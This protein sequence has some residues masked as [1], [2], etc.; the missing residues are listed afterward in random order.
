MSTIG[1]RTIVSGY[2]R[3]K[4]R[5][6]GAEVETTMPTA[7][8]DCTGCQQMR[9]K[10]I[11]MVPVKRGKFGIKKAPALFAGGR[12]YDSPL[13]RRFAEELQNRAR[14]IDPDIRSIVEKAPVDLLA[15]ITWRIDFACEERRRDGSWRLVRY[16]TKGPEDREYA[17]KLRLYRLVGDAPLFIV[18][19]RGRRREVQV[20]IPAP[21]ATVQREMEAVLARRKES[22]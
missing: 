17:L 4:C 16:E 8:L 9:G 14:A 12:S 7:S 22:A 1:V 10:T 11:A 5:K 18:K 2:S 15:G 19:E 21:D 20:V 13:E 6:C 3:W